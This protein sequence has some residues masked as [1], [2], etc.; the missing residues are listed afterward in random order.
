M[1]AKAIVILSCAAIFW[2][3]PAVAKQRNVPNPTVT[4]RAF[5]ASDA[6]ARFSIG[7][8]NSGGSIELVSDRQAICAKPMDNSMREIFFRALFTPRY[9]TNPVY[10]A[11]FTVIENGGNTTLIVDPY[12]EYQNAYGQVTR[13]PFTNEQELTN[14][15]A[16]LERFK[17]EWESGNRSMVSFNA[18]TK[19]VPN[20]Y[21]DSYEEPQQGA[22]P[23]NTEVTQSAESPMPEPTF[24]TA[25]LHPSAPT[26]KVE[27]ARMQCLDKFDLVS[28]NGTQAIFEGTCANK[29]RQLL[30]CRG[31]MCKALN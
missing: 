4:V 14:T 19:N 16:S 23:A 29:K 22:E 25:N 7:C 24:S 9:A 6:I 11:R 17:R 15:Q 20:I 1:Q 26:A 2:A 8:A 10:R 31:M 3:C 13:I 30:E 27:L 12:I 28:D 5:P 18:S 21:S